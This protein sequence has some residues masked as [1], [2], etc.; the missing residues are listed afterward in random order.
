M[1]I[2]DDLGNAIGKIAPTIATA[3]GGPLAGAG[4]AVLAKAL[5]LEDPEKPVPATRVMEAMKTM[6]PEQAAAIRK[7]DN[8]FRERM[9]ELDIEEVA[10]HVEDRKSARKT[11][12]ETKSLTV[13]LLAAIVIAAFIAALAGVFWLAVR[14]DEMNATMATLVG[15]VVG[16]ASAKADQVVSFFF[17]S[18]QGSK[19]KTDALASAARRA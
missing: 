3:L 16:Y 11:W 4:V 17:G 9:R 5:G 7:A 19:E 18:S 13:P 6:T 1:G 10:L 8:D 12:V 14:D 2:L 15:A